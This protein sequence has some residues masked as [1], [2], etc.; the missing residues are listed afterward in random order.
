MNNVAN[1]SA[2]EIAKSLA[3]RIFVKAHATSWREAAGDVTAHILNLK[4][5][6]NRLRV[7]EKQLSKLE[8][9]IEDDHDEALVASLE[10]RDE[11]NVAIARTE[12]LLSMVKELQVQ[13][14]ER[15]A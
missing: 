13:V 12:A 2:Q 1:K 15:A 14:F 4:S 3:E 7:L 11:A 9:F 8:E 6:L 5:E 10:A